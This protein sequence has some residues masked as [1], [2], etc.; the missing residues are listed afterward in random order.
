MGGRVNGWMD[1]YGDVCILK[2]EVIS[3]NNSSGFIK[4][5]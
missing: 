4:Q 3:R 2:K 5:W 1:G